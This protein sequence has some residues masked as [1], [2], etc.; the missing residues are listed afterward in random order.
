MQAIDTFMP[1]F[2]AVFYS[3]HIVVTSDFVSEVLHVPKVDRPDY[4]THSCLT[5]ISRDKLALL[6]REKAMWGGTLNFSITKFTKGPRF[7]N[8]VMTFVLTPW[9]QYNTITEPRAHFL[10]SFMEGLSIDFPSHMIE[11]IIDYYHDTATRDKL[12][13]PSSIT[14]I[15][16]HMHIIISQ[17]PH[18]YR[19]GAI[20]KESIWWSAHNLLQSGCEWSLPMQPQLILQPLPLDPFPLLPLLPHLGSLSPLQTSWSSFSTCMLILV[21]IWNIYPMRCLK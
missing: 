18:F 9:S 4:P 11:S 15:L 8:M 19:M 6:F 12:I 1:Q 13:F 5:S 10:P 3:T 17:S 7:F 2:I 21:V 14:R 20:S 16:T